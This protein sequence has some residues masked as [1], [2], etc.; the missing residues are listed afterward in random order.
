MPEMDGYE[1][2]KLL[3]D[4]PS[5][6]I[7]PIIF[8]TAL[9]HDEDAEIGLAAGAIDYIAKPFHPASVKAKIRNHLVYRALLEKK[10]V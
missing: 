10:S 5:T 3:K 6:A 2:C 4:H 1:V 8:I 9:D 7:I